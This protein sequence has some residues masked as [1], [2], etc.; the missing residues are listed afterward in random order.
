MELH[1]SASAEARVHL[2]VRGIRPNEGDLSP[3]VID[4]LTRAVA[5]PALGPFRVA[6]AWEDLDGTGKW[7]GYRLRPG[8]RE[9]DYRARFDASDAGVMEHVLGTC[10]ER[11]DLVVAGDAALL[12]RAARGF[13]RPAVVP[14]EAADPELAELMH[15]LLAPV[16]VRRGRIVWRITFPMPGFAYGIQLA[17]REAP[18]RSP[19]RWSLAATLRRARE[20]AG[21]STRDVAASGG[22][23]HASV[24]YAENGRDARATTLAAYMR[25]VPAL[26]AQELLPATCARGTMSRDAAWE[27]YRD[28]YGYEIRLL[29]KVCTIAADGKATTVVDTIGLRPLRDDLREL[30]V[31]TGLQLAMSQVSRSV[32]QELSADPDSLTVHE[33]SVRDGPVLHEFRFPTRLARGSLSHR[34]IFAVPR[35]TMHRSELRFEPGRDDDAALAVSLPINHPVQRIELVVLLPAEHSPRWVRTTAWCASA[36]PQP[37]VGSL[38]ARLQ[39]PE[40]R[41]RRRGASM[42]LMLSMLRPVL[43]SSPT[44]MWGIPD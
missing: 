3:K 44:I 16:S 32:M 39:P 2:D 22:I 7:H 19:S 21:L 29:R 42:M 24:V 20:T 5:L 26:T 9:L 12:P 25:A 23:A 31:R 11:L 18:R 33:L 38:T 40:C 30:R 43:G 37:D 15:P 17:S 1:L 27:L 34:R 14:L 36:P 28:L 8:V 35:F 41:S 10:V 4:A 6:E 13:V